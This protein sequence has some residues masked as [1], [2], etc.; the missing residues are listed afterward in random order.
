MFIWRDSKNVGVRACQWINVLPSPND[1]RFVRLRNIDVRTDKGYVCI[2]RK[3]SLHFCWNGRKGGSCISC[4]ATSENGYIGRGKFI[5]SSI[6][7][8][9]RLTELIKYNVIPCDL[10]ILRDGL[11]R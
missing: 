9:N 2:C 11:R 5:I 1:Y 10:H 6:G 8:H 3:K 4:R 7:E